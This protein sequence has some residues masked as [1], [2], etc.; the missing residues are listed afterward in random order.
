[1]RFVEVSYNITSVVWRGKGVEQE[2]KQQQRCRGIK[3]KWENFVRLCVL[4]V[5]EMLCLQPLV[6]SSSKPCLGL[7][8]TWSF[9]EMFCSCSSSKVTSWLCSDQA[10]FGLVLNT[11]YFICVI[12]VFIFGFWRCGSHR[13]GEESCM[14][15]KALGAT[16]RLNVT[17][18]FDIAAYTLVFKGMGFDNIFF[19]GFWS[20]LCLFIMINAVKH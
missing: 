15:R 19:K 14:C 17:F 1:M 10:D 11:Y 13:E 8:S 20:L 12:S 18:P 3:G 7:I 9:L 2:G 16:Q 5:C 4:C 6:T